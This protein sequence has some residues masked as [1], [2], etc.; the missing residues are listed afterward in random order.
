MLNLN[1]IMIGSTQPGVLGEFYEKVLGRPADWT[2]GEW[3]GWKM[4]DGQFVIGRHSEVTAAAKEPQ[5]VVFNFDVDDVEDEFE[6]IKALGAP[7]IKEPY[8][9]GEQFI[10][11]FS[12]PD[13]NY[14]QLITPWKLSVPDDE[15][16]LAGVSG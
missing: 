6:R 12:D 15:L 7:V 1:S 11:T 10:A 9:M 13:G 2:D 5:R 16:E 8:K 14:F 3:R 4:C